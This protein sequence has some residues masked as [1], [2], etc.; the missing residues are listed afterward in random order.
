MKVWIRR[1]TDEVDEM[2]GQRMHRRGVLTEGV[3]SRSAPARGTMQ[4]L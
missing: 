1:Y 3:L 2:M 4:W